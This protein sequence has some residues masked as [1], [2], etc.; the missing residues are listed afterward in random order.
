M[1]K[2][3]Q[4]KQVENS[5]ES[6]V[7]GTVYAIIDSIILK[8][9]QSYNGVEHV[10]RVPFNWEGLGTYDSY[11]IE[12]TLGT[13]EYDIEPIVKEYLEQFI[14][15]EGIDEGSFYSEHGEFILEYKVR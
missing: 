13:L 14:K 4:I 15:Q 3:E 12:N 7:R 9:A 5:R 11:Y 10:V 2:P 8:E 6:I 1:I